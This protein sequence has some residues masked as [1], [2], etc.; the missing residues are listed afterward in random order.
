MSLPPAHITVATLRLPNEEWLPTLQSRLPLSIQRQGE[1]FNPKR[2]QQYIS[3][4]WLLAELMFHQFSCQELPDI[5]TSDNGRPV[6]TDTQL[7][8]F[9]ISHSGEYIM[10]AVAQ[11]GRIGLDVEH[12]RPRRKLMELAQYSFSDD[13]YQWLKNLPE[14]E[15]TDSFWQLWTLRE[16]VLKLSAKGVWQMKQIQIKPQQKTLFADFQPEL[17]C[18]TCRHQDIAWAIS[19]NLATQPIKSWLADSEKCIL[20]PMELPELVGFTTPK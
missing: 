14:S 17:F 12:I 6:F 5:V 2:R 15:Q 16:S 9:N 18:V 8:D 10:V 3:G 11:S 19:T 13:E 7:P 1:R 20:S 4:R